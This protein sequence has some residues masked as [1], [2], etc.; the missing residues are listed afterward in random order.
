MKKFSHIGV[1]GLRCRAAQ[2]SAMFGIGI[3]GIAHW[4]L[5]RLAIALVI[6]IILWM[7]ISRFRDY[8]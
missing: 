1:V 7:V 3:M 8:D 6:L 4:T 2:N 5:G